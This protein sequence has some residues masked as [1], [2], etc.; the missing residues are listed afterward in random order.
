[1]SEITDIFNTFDEIILVFTEMP[2]I[3]HGKK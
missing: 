2:E 3:A 1:M